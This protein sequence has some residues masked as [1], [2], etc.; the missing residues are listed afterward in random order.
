M[1]S[2]LKFYWIKKRKSERRKEKVSLSMKFSALIVVACKCLKLNEYNLLL[3]VIFFKLVHLEHPPLWA[4]QLG[5]G[6]Q[7]QGH[8]GYGGQLPPLLLDGARDIL[9]IDEKIDVGRG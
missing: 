8:E 1:H 6:V 2:Y 5:Y 9:K 3:F 4:V 7:W